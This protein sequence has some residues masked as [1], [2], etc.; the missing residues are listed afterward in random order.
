LIRFRPLLTPKR[1]STWKI[2]QADE[3]VKETLYWLAQQ[4]QD[5]FSQRIYTL[6]E[7]WR[8]CVE[9]STYCIEG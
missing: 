3:Q 5:F 9:G 1:C 6:L 8:Q 7:C 4:P 2:F